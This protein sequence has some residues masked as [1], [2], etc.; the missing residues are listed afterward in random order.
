[1]AD[2]EDHRHCKVCGR[3]CDPDEQTCSRACAQERERIVRSRRNMT[4]LLYASIALVLIVFVAR[5]L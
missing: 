4:F 5:Y 2:E 1:V 3:M